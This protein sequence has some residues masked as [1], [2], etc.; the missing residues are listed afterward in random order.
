MISGMDWTSL[1]LLLY[2]CLQSQWLPW[3][4]PPLPSTDLQILSVFTLPLRDLRF[5]PSGCSWLS[6]LLHSR[7][8]QHIDNIGFL[9][10]QS[11]EANPD[12]AGSLRHVK[13][14]KMTGLA[15]LVCLPC[16][17]TT[18]CKWQQSITVKRTSMGVSKPGFESWPLHSLTVGPWP[19]FLRLTPVK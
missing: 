7:V 1:V 15:Q 2:P 19:S 8:N 18:S 16:Y 13:C 3:S 12:M 17:R 9:N 4:L 5:L 11:W 10:L 6:G 14:P